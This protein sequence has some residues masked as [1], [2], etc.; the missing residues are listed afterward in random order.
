MIRPSVLSYVK[1]DDVKPLGKAKI[2]HT[3]LTMITVFSVLQ[4]SDLSGRYHVT[5]MR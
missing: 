5:Y 1:H 2:T 4:Y 3:F